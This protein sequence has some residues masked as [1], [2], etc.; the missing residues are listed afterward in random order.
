MLPHTQGTEHSIAHAFHECSQAFHQMDE[1][2]LDDTARTW[3]E[4]IKAFMDTSGVTAAEG[5]GRWAAKA[6]SLSADDQIEFS[7]V[8]DELAE[9]FTRKFWGNN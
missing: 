6:R 9:W 3:V 1:S 5:E 4:K 2:S 7:G 8:V